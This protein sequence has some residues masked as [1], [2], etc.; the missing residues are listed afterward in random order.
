ME[1]FE[2]RYFAAV[3]ELENIHQASERINVSASALSK[4]ISRLEESLQV[5]LFTREGRNIRLTEK[6]QIL[7]KQSSRF[8]SLKTKQ[9][10]SYQTLKLLLKCDYVGLKYFFLILA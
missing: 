5:E 2:L 10:Q 8:L 6:G 4:A 3:A 1:I 9:G 7:F